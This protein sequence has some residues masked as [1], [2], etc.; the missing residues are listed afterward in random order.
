MLLWTWVYKDLFETLISILW[1]IYPE[2]R[3]LDHKVIL[4]LIFWGTPVLFSAAAAPFY[5]PTNSAQVFQFLDILE[6]IC[7]FL[8][9]C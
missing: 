2:V 3:W 6:N 9:F 8:C 5:F 4:F 7:Y 1:G